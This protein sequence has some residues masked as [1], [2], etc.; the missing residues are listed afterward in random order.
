MSI[1]KQY[2]K[3]GDRN[4]YC[5]NHF[6]EIIYLSIYI[7]KIL[8]IISSV[9][10]EVSFIIFLKCKFNNFAN[11]YSKITCF[12]VIIFH[13]VLC[14]M[15]VNRFVTDI[16]IIF[17]PIIIN[18]WC[19]LWPINYANIILK[20]KTLYDSYYHNKTKHFGT[21][22]MKFLPVVRSKNKLAGHILT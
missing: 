2:S 10:K 1:W 9:Y 11:L 8:S 21:S 7:N 18:K 19:N 13:N 4:F 12:I 15:Q 5:V 20:K 3:L 17:M 22:L 16:G 14:V 6:K